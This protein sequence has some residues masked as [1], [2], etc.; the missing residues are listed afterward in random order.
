MGL[1]QGQG[2]LGDLADELFET[3]MFLSP[4]F[5]L[6]QQ[7]DRNVSGVG[8]GFDFPG[9]IVAQV[10]LALGTAAVGI[11]ASAANR[12]EAGGQDR[13]FGLEFFLASLE[14]ATDQGGMLGYFHTF[15]R[16]ILWPE[17]L[18]S[19]KAYQLQA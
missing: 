16:A 6:G 1:D 18:N 7:I 17:Q 11:A 10:L 8:F 13:A 9:E 12:H 2:E 3:A 14:E 4:L 19:I 5:D 15:A